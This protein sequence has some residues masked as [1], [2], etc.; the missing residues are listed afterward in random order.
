MMAP[1]VR[2]GRRGR[3]PSLEAQTMAFFENARRFGRNASYWLKWRGF[4]AYLRYQ[5]RFVLPDGKEAGEVLVIA[6]I[7][8]PEA[9]RRRGWFWRYCQLCA[10]LA[11]DG[12]AVES[13]HNVKLAEALRR[14]PEFC[15]FEERQFLMRK[16]GPED[17]PLKLPPDPEMVF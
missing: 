15:E 6:S 8:I 13:V 1:Q 9:W 3:L 10:A 2:A 16:A 7:A 14:R 4:E 11:R 5:P 12:V 17:W